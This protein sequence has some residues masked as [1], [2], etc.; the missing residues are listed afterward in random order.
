MNL[1]AHGDPLIEGVRWE[2]GRQKSDNQ[3]NVLLT[4][5]HQRASLE[6]TTLACT[7]VERFVSDG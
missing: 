2:R 7:S 5:I 1:I 4:V 3:A 6:S